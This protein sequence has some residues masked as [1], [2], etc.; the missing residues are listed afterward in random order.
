MK[1]VVCIK[2]ATGGATG[3][4]DAVARARRTPAGVLGAFDGC[5]VEE[6]VRIRERLG[7][8]AVKEIVVVALAASDT[9]GAL[10]DALAIG[11]DRALLISDP[12]LLD[13]DLLASSRA[14]A[15]VLQKEQADLYLFCPSD[16]D[17]D[18]PMFWAATA[19]RL[20]LP[21][22]TYARSLS[23]ENSVVTVRRQCET[24]DEVLSAPLPCAVALTTT[25]NQPR[26]ATMKGKQQARTR[27]VK[28]LRADELPIDKARVGSAGSGTE[29]L[30]TGAP[31]SR[32]TPTVLDDAAT[33]PAA[34]VAFLEARNAL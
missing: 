13:G 28:L 21:V 12:A 19:E 8:A 29:I 7:T 23:I 34:I 30:A 3:L 14:L 11:A 6:A 32:G 9:L 31:P 27:P 15:A 4:E 25:I 18:G 33:A 10:R 17:V 1:I 22:L 24:G 5:A 20:Q 16:E 2:T 26:Y